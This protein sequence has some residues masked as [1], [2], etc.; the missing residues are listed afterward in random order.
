MAHLPPATCDFETRSACSLPTH[1]TWRYAI[2]P[3]TEI[4]CFGF[5]LPDWPKGEV[6]LWHPAFPQLGIEEEGRREL[7]HFTKWVERGGLVEAHNA[8]FERCIFETQADKY[9]LVHI[10]PNAWRCSA[11]KAAAHALPRDLDDALSAL[12][13]PI[14]KDL[15][16][17]EVMRKMVLP[18]KPLKRDKK[19]WRQLHCPCNECGG[20]GKL[21]KLKRDGTPT[22]NGER[23]WKCRGT[24]TSGMKPPQMPLLYREVKE[25]FYRLFDYNKQDVRAEEALSLALP[26]L[27]PFE[28]RLFAVDMAVNARGFRL[29]MD[30]VDVALTLIEAEQGGLNSELARITEGEVL[31]ATQRDKVKEWLEANGLRIDNT[32]KE[33]LDELLTGEFD[34]LP[35]WVLSEKAHP[36][37]RRVLE[38]VRTVGRSSTA[39]YVAMR[40]WADLSDN[41]VRGGLLYH[42]AS[43]GRWTGKGVQPH[44]F[45]KGGL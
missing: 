9:G 22:K 15:E 27:N 24:G 39:K 45:P 31:K 5:R 20:V 33:T 43:T 38:I 37:V 4:L 1:G 28:Q 21:E 23:C 6:A 30:A 11:A 10:P 34:E 2:H 25:E 13:L 41:R 12:R 19:I 32:R 40:D 44:N 42:G 18:R 26:D 35:P 17:Y 36:D 8:W 3:T 14:H 7:K 16:G 29:D